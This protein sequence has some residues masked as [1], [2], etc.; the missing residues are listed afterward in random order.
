MA[1][2]MGA[3]HALLVNCDDDAESI[4]QKVKEEMDCS[5]EIS[6]EC[7]GTELAMATCIYVSMLI[8]FLSC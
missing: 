5:P 1:D 7:A 8:H 2:E 4:A 6:I 3:D